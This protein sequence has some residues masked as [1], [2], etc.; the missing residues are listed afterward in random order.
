MTYEAS[1]ADKPQM[2]TTGDCAWWTFAAY[3]LGLLR[4][5]LI[6]NSFIVVDKVMPNLRSTGLSPAFG[7]RQPVS[8][9]LGV[10]RRAPIT[11]TTAKTN[12]T[13]PSPYP[14]TPPCAAHTE[15]CTLAAQNSIVSCVVISCP[16]V[17]SFPSRLT[18]IRQD[19]QDQSRV[20]PPVSRAPV[21]TT[22]GV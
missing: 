10:L 22:L 20:S 21:N 5:S 2:S 8:F 17:P 12:H 3:R 18:L 19:A 14:S 7:L 15:L 6:L 4:K 16:F 11:I 9:T 1:Q 13:T